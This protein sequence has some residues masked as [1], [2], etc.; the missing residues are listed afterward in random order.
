MGKIKKINLLVIGGTGFIGFHLIKFAKAKGWKVSS[1]SL[2][3]PSKSKKINGVKYFKLDISKLNPLK[4]ILIKQYDYV[5]NLSGYIDHISYRRGGRRLISQH[6]DSLQNL[7]QTLSRK[8]LKRFVQIGSS[9]E[10]GNGA[11]PQNEKLREH[12]ISPYSLAKISSTHF[13]QMLH[14][15]ENFP[16]TILRFFLV[17]GMGQNRNRFIPQI[18]NGCIKNLKFAT[19]QGNQVRDFCYIEDAVRAIFLA[20]VSKKSEGEIFN[21]GS[22]IPVKIRLVIEL[23]KRIIGKGKPQYGKLK[24]REG[25]NTLLYADNKK[26]KKLLG[27]QAR[28]NL[29]EGLRKTIKDLN[30]V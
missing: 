25:T 2:H 18:I 5:V 20:L 12:A 22:G 29:E 17:Y 11:A 23:V 24:Y 9:D 7:V 6:F 15:T 21:V 27:W 30:K 19:T 3:N 16:A 28:V 4:K 8:K 13:L 26:I 1:V 14:R 10:Y